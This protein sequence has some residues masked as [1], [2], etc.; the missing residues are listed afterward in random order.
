MK[1]DK[2]GIWQMTI[3]T[4]LSIKSGVSQ[5]QFPD[6]PILAP[7]GGERAQKFPHALVRVPRLL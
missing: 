5:E 1:L 7:E 6:A 3:L 2:Q 4:D